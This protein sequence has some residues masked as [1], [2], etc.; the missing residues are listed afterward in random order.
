MTVAARIHGSAHAAGARRPPLDL[1]LDRPART[2]SGGPRPRD[3]GGDATT[4]DITDAV[5]AALAS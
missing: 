2:L 4:T 1:T 3:L 5:I